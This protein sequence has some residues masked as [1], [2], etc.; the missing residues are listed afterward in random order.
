MGEVHVLKSLCDI[1][2]NR[3]THILCSCVGDDGHLSVQYEDGAG[4]A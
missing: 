3:C 4:E 1:L 2:G